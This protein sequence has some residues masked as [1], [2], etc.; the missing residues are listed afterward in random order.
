MKALM[1]HMSVA[2]VERYSHIRQDAKRVA[3][4]A[5]TLATQPSLV[6]VPKDPPKVEDIAVIQ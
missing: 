1:G 3:V 2:R 6:G 4:E 5:L